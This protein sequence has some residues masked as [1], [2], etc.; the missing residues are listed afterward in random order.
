MITPRHRLGRAFSARR[1][2]LLATAANL[3]IAV[4]FVG[5]G[6]HHQS[7]LPTFSTANA[8]ESNAS[9]GRGWIGVQIQPVTSVIAESLGMKETKGALVAES[10]ADGPA[11][12]VGILSGDVITALNGNQIKDARDLA[13]Q[14][15]LMAPGATAK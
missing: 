8:A 14:I 15:G 10:L 4:L 13:K 9:L 11:A 6:G 1:L 2:I 7:M 5:P 3:A 12:K